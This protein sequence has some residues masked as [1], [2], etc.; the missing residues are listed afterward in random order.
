MK[1]RTHADGPLTT[2]KVQ[3]GAIVVT[4]EFDLPGSFTRMHAHT[5]DHWMTCLQGSARI[6]IDAEERII[7]AGDRYLVEAHKRH[8]CWPL[9]SGTVLQCMHEHADIH[10]DKLDSNGIPLEWL[11]RLTER[12]DAHAFS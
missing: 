9:E 7:K 4:M 11:H 5:F 10:P 8:G 12:E 1:Y 2:I 3:P 6:K